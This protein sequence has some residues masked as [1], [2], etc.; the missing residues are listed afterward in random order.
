VAANVRPIPEGHQT[1]VPHLVVRG[2]AEA[3]EFY[4][5]AF[6]AQEHSRSLL[7]DG[8][9]LHAEIQIGDSRIFLA[10]EFPEHGSV[11]PQAL[12]GSPVTIHLWSE[13]VD[14]LFQR[15]Q[16]AGAQV[17]MP[18]EEAFWGDRYGIVMDPYGHRWSMST[19]VKDVT[20]EEMQQAQKAFS[21]GG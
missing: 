18:L 9:L 16:A 15:A 11:S 12:N 2:G 6:G 8:R 4:K 19:H 10:D 13:D 17:A 21:G 7:P 20:P 5:R 1:V 3:I 14:S